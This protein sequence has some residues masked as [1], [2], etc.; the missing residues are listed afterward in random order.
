[1][2][3]YLACKLHVMRNVIEITAE[4]RSHHTIN[5]ATVAQA[6]TSM[7]LRVTSLPDG[8]ISDVHEGGSISKKT[9]DFFRW[10]NFHSKFKRLFPPPHPRR[11]PWLCRSFYL[12]TRHCLSVMLVSI[13]FLSQKSRL[14]PTK[15]EQTAPPWNK[16]HEVWMSEITE[17]NRTWR[18]QH[19]LRTSELSPKLAVS[20]QSDLTSPK[21][22]PLY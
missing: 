20:N 19:L 18:S 1:M 11:C 22:I 2:L 7:T 13:Y 9:A 8:R 6:T 3:D 17:H 12:L 4:D 14:Y 10:V 5:S 21:R 16:T 15:C